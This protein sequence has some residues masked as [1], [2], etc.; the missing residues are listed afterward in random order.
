[1]LK[2]LLLWAF[3][4]R[5]CFSS[6]RWG[7][8]SVWESYHQRRYL[9]C[10]SSIE[11]NGACVRLPSNVLL[12]SSQLS[13]WLSHFHSQS[14]PKVA[15]N[16]SIW[17]CFKESSLNR[18]KHETIRFFDRKTFWG[19]SLMKVPTKKAKCL[20]KSVCVCVKKTINHHHL[21]YSQEISHPSVWVQWRHW[22]E[23]GRGGIK[24]TFWANGNSFLFPFVLLTDQPNSTDVARLNY[25]FHRL[26]CQVAM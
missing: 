16:Y 12:I 13:P 20:Y 15:F 2:T 14:K 22:F 3:F 7:R 23:C 26:Q 24:I 8:T 19:K 18:F 9:F 25:T 17:M 10:S 1:M 21:H 11:I 4:C 5:Y 6:F